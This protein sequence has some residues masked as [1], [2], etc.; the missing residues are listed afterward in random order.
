[1]S[2][3]QVPPGDAGLPPPQNPDGMRL[4]PGRGGWAALT[5][6]EERGD[7]TDPVKDWRGGGRCGSVCVG[8]RRSCRY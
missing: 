8:G 5:V 6:G 3:E 1:M 7:L 4:P 2:G